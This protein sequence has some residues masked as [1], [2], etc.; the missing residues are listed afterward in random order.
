MCML[1]SSFQGPTSQVFL[2]R[3]WT[4]IAICLK[5]LC[6]CNTCGSAS[7]STNQTVKILRKKIYYLNRLMDKYL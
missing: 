1:I 3:E 5:F 4:L 2:K 6:T 7:P